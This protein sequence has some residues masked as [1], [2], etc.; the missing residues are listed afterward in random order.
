MEHHFGRHAEARKRSQ[1]VEVARHRGN[2]QGPQA[3]R[4]IGAVRETVN[5][6]ARRKPAGDASRDVSATHQ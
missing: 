1:S 3:R 2:T 5:P 6:V 4:L